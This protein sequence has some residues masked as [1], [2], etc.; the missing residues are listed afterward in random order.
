MSVTQEIL[1]RI[2]QALL[3][4]DD[5]AIVGIRE[6]YGDEATD[7]LRGMAYESEIES[8]ADY[9]PGLKFVDQDC[10]AGDGS[11]AYVVFHDEI[12]G[13]HVG[14]DGWYSSSEGYEFEDF[15]LVKMEP[16]TVQHWRKN[17]K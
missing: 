5:E 7:I 9:V 16:F 14:F 10:V 8:I 15:N 6:E 2:E 13:E 3:D 12:T 17:S 11:E 1:E 4:S